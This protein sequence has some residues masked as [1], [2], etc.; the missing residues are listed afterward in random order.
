MLSGIML[1]VVVPARVFATVIHFH[2]S[3]LFADQAGA[4][5]SGV[6]LTVLN[7]NAWLPYLA[8]SS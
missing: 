2:I 6:P 4:Y 8:P 3:L 5:N 7:Y 1:N